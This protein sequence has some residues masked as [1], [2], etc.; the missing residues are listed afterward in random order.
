MGLKVGMVELVP[1][2]V[3]WTKKYKYEEKRLKKIFGEYAEKIEHVGSTSI[4]GLSAKP[5]IDIAVGVKSLNDFDKIR[6]FFDN[7]KNYHIKENSTNG[8]ILIRKG[9]VDNRSYYIHVMEIDSDRYKD[10]I[11][12]RDYLRNHENTKMEYEKLKTKLAKKY[13]DDRHTYT[14][15]KNDFIQKIINLSKNQKNS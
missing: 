3:S 5:I 6:S 14:A 11:L 8:E 1:Y 10:T 12:F 7:S 13:A 15:L 9:S 4:E 2:D